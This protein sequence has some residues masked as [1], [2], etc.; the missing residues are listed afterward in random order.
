MTEQEAFQSE[1]FSYDG[2]IYCLQRYS[3]S[4]EWELYVLDSDEDEWEP[5]ELDEPNEYYD[6]II[7][8]IVKEDNWIA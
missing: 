7:E 2:D 1:D 3:L 6:P 4:S 8:L 5:I